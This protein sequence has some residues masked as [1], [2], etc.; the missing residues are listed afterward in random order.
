M[1]LDII[2]QSLNRKALRPQKLFSTFN[3]KSK[4]TQ[5]AKT[6]NKNPTAQQRTKPSG[7]MSPKKKPK[8]DLTK[9]Q[10]ECDTS[11]SLSSDTDQDEKTTSPDKPA[12]K[13]IDIKATPEQK[14]PEKR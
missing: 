1:V 4:F 3:S 14:S 7:K 9:V 11:I 12:A 13:R 10:F 8:I 5:H 2:Q 6:Q